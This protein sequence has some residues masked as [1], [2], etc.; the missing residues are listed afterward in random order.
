MKSKFKIILF[1]IL[2]CPF[3]I[4]AAEVSLSCPSSVASGKTVECSIK[5]NTGTTYIAGFQANLS[6]SSGLTYKSY[7][8]SSGWAGNS[9]SDKFLIYG[10]KVKGSQTLGKYVYTA[11]GNPNQTVTLTMQNIQVSS[12]NGDVVS[13]NKTASATIR[14]KC[15]DNNLKSLTI[16]GK[17]VSN[18]SKDTLS[19]S[20]TTQNSS[21]KIAASANSSYAKVSGTGTKTVNYGS[22][23]FNVVVT[24]E[25]GSQKT[26]KINVTRP[27]NREK[28]NTLN[29]LSVSGYSITPNFSTNTTTYKLDVKS[30]VESI[31]IKATKTSSK[32]SFVSGY[33]DRNVKLNYGENKVLVKV[34]A[35]NETVKTYTIIVT[36]EDNRS[37]NNFLK[38]LSLSEGKIKFNKNTLTYAL[39]TNKKT[40]KIDAVA[41]DSKATITG[42][43]EYELNSGINEIKIVVTAENEKTREYL[44]KV[45]QADD[46]SSIPSSNNLTSLKIID[47]KFSFSPDVLEYQVTIGEE[48]KLNLDFLPEDENS[49]VEVIGNENLKDGSVVTLKVTAINGETK[50]YKINIKK[51]V[52]NTDEPSSNPN[53]ILII[54]LGVSILA[55]I[56]LLVLYLGKNKKNKIPTPT[57]ESNEKGNE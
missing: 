22:N 16:D 11:K 8:I 31:D 33:G 36:R 28:V 10:N 21:I 55:N 27:D 12:D 50:E 25:S 46:L 15:T 2:M 30:D 41:E 3:I 44:I 29:S 56:V 45:T 49:M 54:C 23:T 26:Y 6:P 57:V 14:I 9:S 38:S 34:K 24:S 19:Y 43:K 5:V 39:I 20:L 13:S 4:N 47:N 53:I 51:E 42:L 7:S 37:S 52:E 48:T 40:I 18:F 1:M 32:S 17:S 35:E